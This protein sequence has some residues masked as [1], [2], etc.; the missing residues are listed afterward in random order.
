[1]TDYEMMTEGGYRLDE[2]VSALQKEIRRCHEKEALY[3]ALEVNSKFPDYLWKRLVVIVTEDIGMAN[4]ELVNTI[5]NL[6]ARVINLR[7]ESKRKDYDLCILGFAI[8]AMA[9]S[10]KSREGDDYVNQ[11]LR[12]RRLGWRL[13]VPDYAKDKHTKAGRAMG[14]TAIDFWTE[15][16]KLENE[17]FPSQYIGWVDGLGDGYYDGNCKPAVSTKTKFMQD[18]LFNYGEND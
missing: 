7:K 5:T 9:R 15:G 1:M 17:A 6:S 12:E 10:K 18:N 3:W 16:S 14:K 11:I 8:L 2:A 13:E 4:V